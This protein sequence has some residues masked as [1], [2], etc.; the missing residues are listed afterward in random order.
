[1][2]RRDERREEERREEAEEIA[3]PVGYPELVDENNPR[4][5]GEERDD[6]MGPPLGPG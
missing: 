3:V 1:M 4:K 5:D 2:D 6:D